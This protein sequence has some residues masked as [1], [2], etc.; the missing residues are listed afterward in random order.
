MFTGDL[1]VEGGD[2]LLNGP[3]GAK[4]KADY[5][6]MV[7]HGQRGVSEKFYQAVNPQYCLW[8]TPL[9]LWNNDNG[10]GKGSGSWATLEVHGWMDKLNIQKHYISCF[11]LCKIE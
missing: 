5:V 1:G 11:G 3:Y 4:L 9:W 8:P 10:G 2:K 6:Q 7:H